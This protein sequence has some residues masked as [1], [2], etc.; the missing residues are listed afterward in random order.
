MSEE[1][2]DLIKG[3]DGKIRPVETGNCP[4]RVIT[5]KVNGI[6]AIMC[7]HPRSRGEGSMFET[8]DDATLNTN[9]CYKNDQ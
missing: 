4:H 3:C 1:K 6:A 2:I 5:T 8:C 9:E 7:G